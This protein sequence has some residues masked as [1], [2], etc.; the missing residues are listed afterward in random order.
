MVALEIKYEGLNY[1]SDEKEMGKRVKREPYI[2]GRINSLKKAEKLY[3]GMRMT[4]RALKGN[5]FHYV[6]NP[7]RKLDDQLS[8]DELGGDKISCCKQGK[9]NLGSDENEGFCT[10]QETL[11]D[12]LALEKE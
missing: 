3:G 2:L 7:N 5:K 6:F 1:K 10:E 12:I 11:R 4:N 8:D 9:D